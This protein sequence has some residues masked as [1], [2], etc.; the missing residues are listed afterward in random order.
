MA[1]SQAAGLGVEIIARLGP[2]GF[3]WIRRR[4]RGKVILVVGP[5]E[6]GK[7]TFIEYLCWN[8][9]HNERDTPRTIHIE[10]TPGF[11]LEMG[12]NRMFNISVRM[13]VDFPGNIGA[14]LQAD[15]TFERNPHAIIIF[16]DLADSARK[17]DDAPDIWLRDF[18]RHLE[19]LWRRDGRKSRNRAKVIVV[20][21]NKS[22]KIQDPQV[23]KDKRKMFCKIIDTELRDARGKIEDEIAVLPCALVI[24]PKKDE[25]AQNIILHLAKGLRK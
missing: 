14:V 8:V 23:L 21:M 1:E 10:K 20:V 9:F 16:T 3:R 6:V 17:P 4:F 22:D 19:T 18:C 13:M 11:D 24:N 2:I 15:E 25:E 5:P 12:L 7:T